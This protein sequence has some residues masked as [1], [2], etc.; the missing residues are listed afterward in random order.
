MP[1][2]RIPGSAWLW[3][4]GLALMLSSCGYTFGYRVPGGVSLVAVPQFLNETF[5]LR[6]EVDFELTRA[7]KQELQLRSDVRVVSKSS[8]EGILEGTILSFQEGVLTE[9]AL[10]AVQES[11]IQVRVRI[12]FIRT[13]DES[14]IL[15]QIVSDHA[16]FS[17]VAGETLEDARRE[18]IS[19]IAERIVSRL[20]AWD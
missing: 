8:A 11:S 2:S 17:N 20:E 15:D 16:D 10:D 13:A 4:C 14:V 3:L 6:R 5:P 19:E 1:S 9:G 7:V 18:A 12:R